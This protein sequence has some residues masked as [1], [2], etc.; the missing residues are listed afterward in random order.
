[1]KRK[2]TADIIAFFER[3][4]FFATG[5]T[6]K[7]HGILGFGHPGIALFIAIWVH[8][9]PMPVPSSVAL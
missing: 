6:A 7:Q 3:A 8:R 2:Q 9:P 1:M 5:A 4:G